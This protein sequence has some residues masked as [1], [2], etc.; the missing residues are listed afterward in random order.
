[1]HLLRGK[2]EPG[3]I[4]DACRWLYAYLDEPAS[5]GDAIRDGGTAGHPEELV[6]MAAVALQVQLFRQGDEDRW[7][8]LAGPA[9]SPHPFAATEEGGDDAPA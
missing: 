2:V 1:M 5:V 9:A 4:F 7:G 6:K 3:A 8:L